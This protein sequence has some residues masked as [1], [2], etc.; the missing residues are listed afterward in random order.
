MDESKKAE[1]EKAALLSTEAMEP[2]KAAEPEDLAL[3]RTH[4]SGPMK[5]P[6][7]LSERDKVGKFLILKKIGQGGMGAV[8]SAYDPDLDRKVALKVLLL[9]P[10]TVPSGLEVG[11]NIH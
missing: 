11:G 5:I 9:S 10:T 4:D 7:T 6:N 2:I 3:A 1:T 8:Y